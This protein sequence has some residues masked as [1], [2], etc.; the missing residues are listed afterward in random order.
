MP[1]SQQQ[2]KG[3]RKFLFENQPPG[4]APHLLDV[5]LSGRR[6]DFAIDHEDER[7]HGADFVTWNRELLEKAERGWPQLI[8]GVWG[9]REGPCGMTQA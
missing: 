5:S 2:P 6:V 9:A 8:P 4:L 1:S 7:R 3:F